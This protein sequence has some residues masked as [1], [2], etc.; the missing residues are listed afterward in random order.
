MALDIN[1]V[2][3]LGRERLTF[4]PSVSQPDVVSMYHCGPTVY[5]R[6]HIGN[7]RAYVFADTLRRMFEA[8]GYTVLQVINIT[9][10]GH[11]VSDAD[12]GADKLE[13]EAQKLNLSAQHIADTYTAAFLQD[14]AALG[15]RTEGTRFPKATEHIQEQIELIQKLE[16]AGHTY[17]LEDGVY[18]DTATYA[19]YGKLGSLDLEG[20]RAGA[21][22]GEHSDKHNPSD[23]ALWKFS[24]SSEGTRQQE[25]PSPWGVGFPGWHIECSAMSM[26][27]LGETFDIHTGG[28]DHISV[29]HNNEIAQS[30]AVTHVPLARYWMHANFITIDGQKISKSLGN[31][32]SL[33][34]LSAAGITP[35]AYRYWLLTSHYA[36]QANYTYEALEGAQQALKRLSDRLRGV[37]PNTALTDQYKAYFALL[38][39]D[40][41]TPALLGEIWKNLKT[42]IDDA[43]LGTISFIVT[44]LLGLTFT[45][46]TY[47]A[48]ADLPNEVQDIIA[49]RQEARAS[50]NWEAS[51]ALRAHIEALGYGIS[52]TTEGQRVYAL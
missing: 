3:T 33:D 2:S 32:L 15:V 51:D 47:L 43:H 12:D 16:A 25:W 5:Q 45:E 27:Y 40:A 31:T 8:A 37:R 13:R 6:A 24:S 42:D 50:K 1:L 9:D 22:I 34:Q 4:I 18:F 49:Q 10:V 38:A 29:H 20:Q 46:A 14:L 39:N 17:Q 48:Y 26:K 28:I 19:S 36:S 30:E 35:A 11:L 44:D 52:D 23:F 7:L 21:R 41:N